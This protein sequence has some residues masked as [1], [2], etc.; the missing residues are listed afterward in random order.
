MPTARLTP[1]QYPV[2][3]VCNVCQFK[4]L[5]RKKEGKPRICPNCRSRRW[6]WPKEAVTFFEANRL[7]R[8]RKRRA[9]AAKESH[10]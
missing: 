4:W 6:W 1:D 3:L 7:E 2:P 9:A 8:D 10:R 5:P